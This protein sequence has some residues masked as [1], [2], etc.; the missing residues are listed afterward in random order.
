MPFSW[1]LWSPWRSLRTSVFHPHI[2]FYELFVK[3]SW[4]AKYLHY[5]LHRGKLKVAPKLRFLLPQKV[6]LNTVS[7]TSS[8][9]H[10]FF[11]VWY[12]SRMKIIF[13]EKMLEAK[14]TIGY[15]N[16]YIKI[17][18]IHKVKMFFDIWKKKTKQRHTS[19]SCMR[20]LLKNQT[21]FSEFS[22]KIACICTDYDCF[23]IAISFSPCNLY[24]LHALKKKDWFRFWKSTKEWIWINRKTCLTQKECTTYITK[25]CKFC[26]YW[27]IWNSSNPG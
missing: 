10:F 2:T 17:F 24:E 13:F 27:C 4:K 15:I 5:F 26:A 9:M 16:V 14:F 8:C 23:K 20:V 7:H 11:N 1:P 25:F 22:R 3:H 19:T 12:P 6:F 18:N 21:L